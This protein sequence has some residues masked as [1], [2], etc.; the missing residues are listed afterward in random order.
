MNTWTLGLTELVITWKQSDSDIHPG[1]T[2]Q[3]ISVENNL[4]YIYQCRSILSVLVR[5]RYFFYSSALF[6][7]DQC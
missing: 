5:Q 6:Y 2:V 7:F 4:I 3:F 1:L